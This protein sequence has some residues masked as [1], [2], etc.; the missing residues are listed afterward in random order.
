MNIKDLI[1]PKQEQQS[2]LTNYYQ[3]FK[4]LNKSCIISETLSSDKNT[5]ALNIS[6]YI[7]LEQKRKINPIIANLRRK[8]E[9]R[10]S[11]VNNIKNSFI[12]NSVFQEKSKMNSSFL[13]LEKYKKEIIS[14]KS[15]IPKKIKIK[16]SISDLNN[17]IDIIKN[18]RYIFDK[19]IVP[20]TKSDFPFCDLGKNLFENNKY[21]VD[22][23][24]NKKNDNKENIEL[25][26]MKEKKDWEDV[27]ETNINNNEVYSNEKYIENNEKRIEQLAKDLNL[28]QND[29]LFP[30]INMRKNR[31]FSNNNLLLST[32]NISEVNNNTTF[33]YN[34]NSKVST[35]TQSPK[36]NSG[37]KINN[38]NKLILNK[39]YFDKNKIQDMLHKK[40]SN[41][42]KIYQ[43]EYKSEAK[44]LNSTF[45]DKSKDIFLFKKIFYFCEPKCKTKVKNKSFDNKLNLLYAENEKQF[46]EKISKQGKILNIGKTDIDNKISHISKRVKFIKKVFDYAFPDILIYKIKNKSKINKNEIEEKNIKKLIYQ[47]DDIKEKLRKKLIS[48]QNKLLESIKIEK[49]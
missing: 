10:K 39:F 22:M 46:E 21:L 31:S 9:T 14:P 1:Q 4:K 43:K 25:K 28:F 12:N 36:N 2:R 23:M 38:L 11:L 34:H 33:N 44:N 27:K 24:T 18:K 42:N 48:K 32:N 17:S 15:I 26:G 16:K 47:N 3:N 41:I 40:E 37:K 5:N 19:K 49:L 20:R 7:N 8:T 35:R 6:S 45:L 29:K 30:I 13:H